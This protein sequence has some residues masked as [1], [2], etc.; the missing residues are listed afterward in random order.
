MSTARYWMS[1]PKKRDRITNQ[2]CKENW[3]PWLSLISSHI[4][5]KNRL[6]STFKS[7]R[8][9]ERGHLRCCA[10]PSVATVYWIPANRPGSF[11]TRARTTLKRPFQPMKTSR[12]WPRLPTATAILSSL[13]KSTTSTKA[14]HF[15]KAEIGEFRG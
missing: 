15:T 11:W 2:Y 6:N 9:W 12:P 3:N 1:R 4:N 7:R 14:S 8:S 10:V 13:G 5:L